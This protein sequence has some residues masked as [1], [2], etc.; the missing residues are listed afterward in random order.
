[1][2]RALFLGLS[3]SLGAGAV[4]SPNIWRSLWHSPGG[5]GLGLKGLASDTCRD[6]WEACRDACVWWPWA[7]AEPCWE[8]SVP[9][10]PSLLVLAVQGP[11]LWAVPGEGSMGRAGL[12]EDPSSPSTSAAGNRGEGGDLKWDPEV[13][14]LPSL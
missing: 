10:S 8:L 2:S 7:A 9:G 1:M 6:S 14:H 13:T 12:G 11:F 5:Q 4:P 3:C